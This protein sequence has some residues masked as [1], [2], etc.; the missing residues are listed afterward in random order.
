MTAV[1]LTQVM[2]T[3]NV[4]DCTQVESV[5]YEENDSDT[6]KDHPLHLTLNTSGH[7]LVLILHINSQK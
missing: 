5:L 4:K 6:C 7:E 3:V 1:K 2:T